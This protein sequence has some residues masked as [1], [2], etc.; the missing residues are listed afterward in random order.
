MKF[1]K[2]ILIAL[3]CVFLFSLT[4]EACAE[5][6]IISPKK[7]NVW[8]EGKTYT[9]K[10]KSL[11]EGVICIAILIGGHYAG[12]INDCDS[13]A[14]QGKFK[15]RIPNGFVS[16]F[17]KNSDN[18]VRVV[19]YYKDNETKSFYSDYFTISK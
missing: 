7:G 10:W 15:W 18:Y 8:H 19:L 14:S 2:R 4:L 1:L 13:C 12:V 11:D 6:I 3:I 17:G 16:G 9:I 5:N